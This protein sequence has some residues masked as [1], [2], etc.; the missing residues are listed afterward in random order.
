MQAGTAQLFFGIAQSVRRRKAR[1][2]RHVIKRLSSHSTVTALPS[3]RHR[4]TLVAASPGARGRSLFSFADECS[5]ACRG[6]RTQGTE[7]HGGFARV[8]LVMLSGVACSVWQPAAQAISRRRVKAAPS[9]SIHADP[10]D[11]D[12]DADPDTQRDP[13]RGLSHDFRSAGPD[14][15]RHDQRS[16]V[17]EFRVCTL[18]SRINKSVTLPDRRSRL[19]HERPRRCRHRSG[20][21]RRA[22]PTSC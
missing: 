19:S 17:G 8:R 3:D 6:A 11:A 20:R 13:G 2:S 7:V 9:S 15:Q 18:P 12:A 21:R 4:I 5:A 10:A 22:R 14:R 1:S 16:T